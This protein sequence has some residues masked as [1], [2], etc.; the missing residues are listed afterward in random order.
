MSM[1]CS[2]LTACHREVRIGINYASGTFGESVADVLSQLL[3]I[4]L[5]VGAESRLFAV[6]IACPVFAY[7]LIVV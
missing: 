7:F 1:D 6:C 2:G 5:Q 3:H 4:S